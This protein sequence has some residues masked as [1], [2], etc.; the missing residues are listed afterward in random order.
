MSQLGTTRPLPPSA[1]IGPGGQSVSE[2]AQFC[3]AQ[4]VQQPRQNGHGRRQYFDVIAAI[5]RE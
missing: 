5:G 2:A 1:D 4:L 3:L